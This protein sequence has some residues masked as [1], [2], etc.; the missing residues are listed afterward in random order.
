MF[1]PPVSKKS[2]KLAEQQCASF[3]VR[4]F[5][6]SAAHLAGA[7]ELAPRASD[8]QAAPLL[9]LAG[10]PVQS[11]CGERFTPP[12]RPIQ[13][14]LEV[15][16]VDDPLERE[17]DCIAEQVMRMS[18]PGDVIA[19]ARPRVSRTS[20]QAEAHANGQTKP[21]GGEVPA[22]VHEALRTPGQCLDAATR[23]IFE[24]RFGWDF[25][26]VR[27]HTDAK[28]AESAR[29]LGARAYTLGA[30]IV[31]APNAFSPATFA[32]QRLLAHELVHT[33]QHAPP[34]QIRRDT[35]EY[36]TRGIA[37]DTAEMSKWAAQSYWEQKVFAVLSV[38]F[39]SPADT[40]LKAPEERD[41]VL[42]ALWSSY[43]SLRPISKEARRPVTIPARPQAT[44][45]G[46]AA[47]APAAGSA[48]PALAY[49]FVFSPPARG[50]DTRERVEVQFL[51]AGAT[52]AGIA[53][54][55][56]KEGV[57]GK[58][59]SEMSFPPSRDPATNDYEAYFRKY[60]DEKQQIDTYL[61]GEIPADGQ[62]VTTS[63]NVQKKLHETTVLIKPGPVVQYIAESKPASAAAPAGYAKHDIGDLHLEKSAT[64]NHPLGKVTLPTAMPADEVLPVK[65]AVWQYF[66][67]GTRNAEVDA[68]VPL[69][70]TPT[71]RIFY[72]LKFHGTTNDVDVVRVGEEGTA[73][74]VELAKLTV[75]LARIPDYAAH[76]SDVKTLSAWLK[77]RYPAIKPAGADV[78][79]MK[80]AAEKA[81]EAA[82]VGSD[83]FKNNYGMEEL[84]QSAA[85]TRLISAQQFD[86]PQAADTKDFVPDERRLV[87]RALEALGDPL[88]ARLRGVPIAR[89]KVFIEARG[90]GKA[91]TYSPDPGTSGLT[92]TNTRSVGGRVTSVTQTITFYD[93][94]FTNDQRL[95]TGGAR[96]VAPASE[97]TPLHEFGHV[98]GGQEGIENA[99]KAKFTASKATLKTAPITWYA[100]SNPSSEFFPEAFALFHADPEW[101]KANLPDM[102]AWFEVLSKTGQPPP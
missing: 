100:K 31:F 73:G 30:D 20:A 101:M 50:K 99:F 10:I 70:G 4:P 90:R 65:F 40:R 39:M 68:I 77:S 97:E 89:Q 69:P 85:R 51:G 12:P 80:A 91:R 54:P 93:N 22:I 88:L 98:I 21:A 9:D 7:N 19:P 16:S 60:P 61:A 55:A 24:P 87:E 71:R 42:S 13:A 45:G 49:L 43:Q 5:A 41:A 46:Q 8:Q 3:S 14:N 94:W 64:G 28:A 79:A 75:D 53:A 6:Q 83:W 78:P 34:G 81:I 47:G 17:A 32:G 18:G 33:A 96:T 38:T 72:T 84:S 44:P 29:T 86:G 35:K 37:L 26:R 102:F 25:S 36:Q 82:V 57:T 52:A 92:L 27:V 1:A 48:A 66:Q 74:Q 59:V 76:S 62:L 63:S 2:T 95:F 11:P 67:S 15:G 23:G 56:A 58:S